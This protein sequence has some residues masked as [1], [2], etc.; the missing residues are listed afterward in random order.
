V[1]DRLPTLI[2]VITDDRLDTIRLFLADWGYNTPEDRDSA[3]DIKRINTLS[4][5]DMQQL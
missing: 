1:E 2:N 3:A 4:L 5:S